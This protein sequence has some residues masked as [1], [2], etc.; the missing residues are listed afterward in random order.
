M[1]FHRPFGVY[2]ILVN[3]GKL[4]VIHK[5]G[6]PYKNRWDLPGGNLEERETLLEALHREFIEETGL[7]IEVLSQVG[8][9]DFLIETDWRQG[10]LVHHIG[11]LYL[12]KAVGGSI[13]IPEKFDGQDSLGA[14]W[15]S[16]EDMLESNASPLVLKA[17]E[18]LSSHI[19]SLEATTYREWKVKL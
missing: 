2:G 1:N 4:M 16:L 8:A 7:Q 9:F 19:N 15:V 5:G 11:I 14:A 18:C 3:E 10:T 12:V 13:C 6:G 17:K